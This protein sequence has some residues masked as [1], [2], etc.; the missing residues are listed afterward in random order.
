MYRI[1]EEIENTIIIQKSEF[2]THLF[3]V[4]TIDDVNIVDYDCIGNT[5]SIQPEIQIDGHTDMEAYSGI[6]DDYNLGITL[7]YII[8]NSPIVFKWNAE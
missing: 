5:T 8:F 2:I 6:S 7:I 3:R 4:E 1:Q